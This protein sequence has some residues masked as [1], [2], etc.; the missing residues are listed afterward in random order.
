MKASPF[1]FVLF[2]CNTL[3]LHYR[4]LNNYEGTNRDILFNNSF[5]YIHSHTQE[6]Q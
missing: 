4:V 1:F 2:F 5:N 3:A 6:R